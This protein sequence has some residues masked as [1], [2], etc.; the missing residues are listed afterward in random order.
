MRESFAK[1]MFR[2]NLLRFRSSIPI[3]PFLHAMAAP[4]TPGEDYDWS[5]VRADWDSVSSILSQDS[6]WPEYQS[7]IQR[8]I[9]EGIEERELERLAALGASWVARGDSR[10]PALLEEIEDPPFVLYYW[11][12][13]NRYERRIAIV[14]SRAS[15][16]YGRTIA[17]QFARDLA[18]SKYEVVSGLARGIDTAAHKGALLSSGGA[19]TIA[20]L[21]CGIN[22][23]Y[24]KENEGLKK[25]IPSHGALI[26]EFPLDTPPRSWNFPSRNRIISGV[27]LATVVVE[28]DERSGSL[29]TARLSAEAARAVMAVPGPVNKPSSRG[30]N[31]LIREGVPLVRSVQ[32]VLS[33][34]GDQAE[35]VPSRDG[36]YESLGKDLAKVYDL[37]REGQHT[38]DDLLSCCD[39]EF[40]QL[41]RALFELMKR[42]L[43]EREGGHLYKAR[44]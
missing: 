8:F 12:D 14:G 42:G 3:E 13:L 40:G 2:L 21:G 37:V 19:G 43:I 25:K 28:A 20:V 34:L 36:L 39:I 29:I 30:C 15:T 32:D 26:S 6:R 16:V 7:E 10:Y 1:D 9:R 33:E 5:R 24:P 23:P 41:N 4:S 31:A 11:G 17:S 44:A 27:S 22:V 38:L 18:T 35:D